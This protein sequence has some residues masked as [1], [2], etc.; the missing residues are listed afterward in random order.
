MSPFLARRNDKST[1]KSYMHITRE[2]SDTPSLCSLPF[3]LLLP[4]FLISDYNS[5][6]IDANTALDSRPDGKAT[7]E[8]I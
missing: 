5:S 2:T 6:L 7:H 4:H 3:L 1:T 8:G